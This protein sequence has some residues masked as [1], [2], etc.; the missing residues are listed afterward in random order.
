MFDESCRNRPGKSKAA[1]L[2]A[3]IM[4][5]AVALTLLLAPATQAQEYPNKPIRI[6]VPFPPGALTDALGRL[7]ADKLRLKFNQTVI[8][9]NRAGAGGNVGSE[10]VA[11]SE[12]DGYTLLF[13]APPPLVINKSLYTK[14]SY[15]PDTFVPVTTLAAGPLALIVNPKVQAENLPQLIALAKANPGKL[16]FASA[17]AGTTPHL[18]GE[19][20]KTMAGIQMTHV[21]Y[22]GSALALTDVLGGQVDLM[23]VEL[24]SVLQHISAGNVRVLALGSD[25]RNTALPNV[26]TMSETLPGFFAATWFGVVAPPR[27]PPAIASRLAAAITESLSHPDVVQR[28]RDAR[29]D[30]MGGTPADMA[31]FLRQERERWGGVIRSSGATAQ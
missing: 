10:S 12:P 20:L 7:V 28:L 21:P 1:R 30:P 11:R 22:K 24:P 4:A 6:V 13:S 15:D 18:A 5:P 17:G 26:P 3:T 19:L 31:T 27:T 25:R 9:E 2:V 8:V 16:N 23:F 29:L 14:L